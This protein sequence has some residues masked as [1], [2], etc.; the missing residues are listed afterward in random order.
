MK[1]FISYARENKDQVKEL[2]ETLSNL[3]Y[4]VWYDHEISGGEDWW[5]RIVTTIQKYDIFIFAL[6]PH[7]TESLACRAEFGYAE[8]L[9]KPIL[10]VL[11]SAAELPRGRLRETHYV[12]ASQGINKD[13]VVELSR[14]LKRLSDRVNAGEFPPPDPYPD[15]PEFPFPPDPLEEI[16]PK[17]ENLES[18]S[19]DE[20]FRVITELRKISSNGEHTVEEARKL[21]E[22]IAGNTRLPYDVVKFARVSLEDVSGRASSLRRSMTP[23]LIG[24]MLAVIVIGGGLLVASG[25]LEPEEIAVVPTTTNTPQTPTAQPTNADEPSATSTIEPSSTP[26]PAPT[27]TITPTIEPTQAVTVTLSAIEALY[28]TQTAESFTATPTS[29][30]PT[31]TPLPPISLDNAGLVR[32]AGEP[33]EE[34][35]STIRQIAFSPD[36]TLWASGSS[37]N[38]VRV[39]DTETNQRI[40]RIDDHTTEAGD[41]WITG[42]VFD[43]TGERLLTAD[44]N[45]LVFIWDIDSRDNRSLERAPIWSAAYSLDGSLFALGLGTGEIEIWDAENLIL[46]T[47]I[48][49]HN[50]LVDALDFH[51]NGAFI[52]S[53]GSDDIARVWN[54]VTGEQVQELEVEA[55]NQIRVV[56]FHPA[57]Q[58]L[59]YGARNGVV[60][61]WDWEQGE[62]LGPNTF[63]S[64]DIW[65]IDVSADGQ[66]VAIA[67]SNQG[68]AFLWDWQA[69]ERLTALSGHTGDVRSITFSTDGSYVLTGGE[70]GDNSIRLWAVAE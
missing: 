11:L 29:P 8:L 61:V 30:P 56:Q 17:V 24:V 1:I 69:D 41:G 39:W 36:G 9:N 58:Y 37:D 14:S 65:D 64:S 28:A 3:D 53:G 67:T 45:G 70:E 6:S 5:D 10:P 42:L 2:E 32:A 34:H 55:D 26:M 20:I 66:V 12:D 51:P 19:E 15:K 43:P 18:L 38:T 57:G 21:L 48:E 25:I 52:A 47:T 33:I 35:T 46:L 49:A 16:R 59:F 63:A 4:D 27:D 22:R 68:L 13:V 40:W 60:R 50:G 54:V 23:V 44:R 7:S 62:R 31:A